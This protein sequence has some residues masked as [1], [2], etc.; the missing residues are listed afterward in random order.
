MN[1]RIGVAISTTG[2]EHRMKFLE[3]CVAAWSNLLN[4]HSLFVTVDGSAEDTARAAAAVHDHTESVFRVG[5]VGMGIP[6]RMRYRGSRMG[7]ATNKNTGLE[8]LM[9]HTGV[10]HLFLCDDD[11]WPM[12]HRALLLHTGLLLPHSMV[13]WGASRKPVWRATHAEWSWPRGV[14]LYQTR[15]VVAQVGG[16]DEAFGPGGHEHA[17]YSRRIHQH[18]LT[19]HPF[20]SPLV[21]SVHRGW[22]A[23]TY[24]HA[25]D[26][27]RRGE[28]NGALGSRR[29]RITTVRRQEGDWSKIDAVMQA[30]DGDTSYVPFRAHENGRQSATLCETN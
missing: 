26:M 11:T 2:D 25:E 6:D 27:P 3:T 19:P 1:N 4:V 8:L 18:G 10:D 16:M 5:Q 28:P 20:V 15:D 14:V 29:R 13:C 12:D 24:W 23:R 21:Y 17:E 7:V 9:D 22:G 30:R